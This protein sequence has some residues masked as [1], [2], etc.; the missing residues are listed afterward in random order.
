M[1]LVQAL[2]SLKVTLA[3]P[4]KGLLSVA[5]SG[6]H[7]PARSVAVKDRKYLALRAHRLD[8]HEVLG[9]AAFTV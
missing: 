6:V 9:V 7:E 8:D 2:P 4:A 3:L 5:A 1:S